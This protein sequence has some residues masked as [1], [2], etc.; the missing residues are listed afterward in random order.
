MA[1]IVFLAPDEK[2]M[3]TA[4]ALAVD[5]FSDIFV[6]RGSLGEGLKAAL[7]LAEEGAEIFIAR[8]GTANAIR[9]SGLPITVVEVAT[10][11]F[12]IIR[13]VDKAK[14]YGNRIA[15]LSH[16][17]LT[18]G[19]ETLGSIMDVDIRQ[20][21]L[22]NI[23]NESEAKA[24]IQQVFSEGADVIIGG[25]ANTRV[26]R[27]L[28]RPAVTIE[29]GAEGI[30]QAF[31]EAKL[32]VEAQN[33]EKA[34]ANLFRALLDYAYEGI[35]S[36]DSDNRIV[37][38]NPV[39]GS[40]LGGQ[41]EKVVGKKASDLW[42]ELDLEKVL[43]QGR[44]ELGQ[45]L[46]IGDID[47]L[48]NTVSVNVKGKPVGAVATFQEVSKIQQMEAQ[49][50][51]RIYADGHVA[52]NT[53]KDIIGASPSLKRVVKIAKEYAITDS[54]V[55]ILGESGTGK[56]MFAQ[57]IHNYSDRSNGPFVA[58]NCAALP[59]QLL[60]S[61]LFGYVGGAFTGA[62]SRGK[63]GLFEVAHEGTIF[64]DEIA[65]MDYLTQ[66]KLLRALQERKIMR[67]GSDKIIPVNVRVLTA[68]NKNLKKMVMDKT[69]RGDLYYR[70]NVLKLRIPPLRDRYEDIKLLAEYF[71]TA[72]TS[73]M[74]HHLQLS[75]DAIRELC[76]YDWP[77][78]IRELQS[79]MERLSAIYKHSVVD[80][81]T[82]R[83]L[84][85][86]ETEEEFIQDTPF[87]SD[88]ENNIRKTLDLTGG[89][90]SEAARILGI[91]RSTLWRKIKKYGMK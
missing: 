30:L 56:E 27:E 62:S 13:A 90:Y 78:N 53:F 19:V 23:T 57:S 9:N 49:L 15:A 77:G 31:T 39:A 6:A 81:E 75:P 84:L 51:R 7:K 35:I 50:R 66:G 11:G 24:V 88:E 5:G 34:R 40:I 91:G 36:V 18:K 79:I 26:V 87:L 54:S 3:T 25:Y 68:T 72:H 10:T 22:N 63:P 80:A 69:F 89:N 67:L 73:I 71:L 74:K 2:V 64:L 29:I 16:S 83:K 46:K 47:V 32:I 41:A 52:Y 85:L 86:E 33:Q 65:E 82:I 43:H 17:D 8:G 70:L 42:P 1:Q 12:D 14:K 45:I 4:Q 61:E 58:V 48:C 28:N 37:F 44:E 76:K 55:L 21:H 59:G 38:F 60:E 20:Y